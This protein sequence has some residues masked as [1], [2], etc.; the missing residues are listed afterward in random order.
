MDAFTDLGCKFNSTALDGTKVRVLAVEGEER[1]G[2]LYEFRVRFRYDAGRLSQDQL[3]QLLLAPCVLVF[4]GDADAV[5]GIAR[6]VETEDQSVTSLATG[7]A[8]YDVVLVPTMWL[9]TVSKVSRLYQA[10][11]VKD[12]AADVLGRYKLTGSH[13]DLRVTGSPRELAIQ[14]HESDW[15][16]LQR[17]FEHEGYFYWF[18]H[19]ASGEK[20]VVADANAEATLLTGDSFVPYRE[21]GELNRSAQSVFQWRCVQTRIPARVFLRDYNYAK[22][23][24]A[25]IGQADI[26]KKLGFGTF[27]EYGDNFDTPDAGNALAKVRAQRFLAA[28]RTYSGVTDCT[29][30]HVGHSFDLSDHPDDTQNGEYLITAIQHRVGPI[31]STGGSREVLGYRA[32]FEAI[33]LAVQFRPERKTEWPSIHGVIHGHIDSD[34]AGK[35][36]T[37]DPQGRYRVRFPFDGTG[38]TG[39]QS[40]TWVRLMQPYSG[41]GYGSHHPLHKGTE[42]IV[43]FLDGDPDRPVILGTVPNAQ[44]PGVSAAA[45]ATQSGTKTASGIHLTMDDSLSKS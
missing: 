11:S 27:F 15:D 8:V 42:V 31:A 24:L 18:E 5:H 38:K 36:S 33:P 1:L 14:Y 26:D 9:L 6:S 23:A 2:E 32:T 19:S 45:N 17:W 12:M 10:M 43:A 41:S 4:D 37:L 21:A 28:Q 13:Y 40:S 25:I 34:S 29:R 30:F 22:P 3:D 44:T 39:E 16:F 35:F 7:S 20:L